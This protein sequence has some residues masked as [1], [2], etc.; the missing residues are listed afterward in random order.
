LSIAL[1]TPEITLIQLV[2]AFAIF[3][4]Q[5]QYQPVSII[6]KINQ[7]KGA[8]IE[9]TS[10]PPVEALTPSVTFLMNSLLEEVVKNGTAQGA[11]QL[12]RPVAGKT[13]TTN[14][15]RSAWFVGYTPD[16][17]TGVYV[18]MDDNTTLGK[19]EY[20]SK[21]ALPIW[22]SFMQAATQ[23][24]PRNAFQ[25]P[26][27]GVIKRIINTE[28]GLLADLSDQGQ[29][30]NGDWSSGDQKPASVLSGLL[31]QVFEQLKPESRPIQDA[32]IPLEPSAYDRDKAEEPY[33]T[34]H[35]ALPPNAYI[36]YFLEGT[37]PRK[38]HSELPPPPLEMLEGS[39][40][41]P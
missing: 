36:E 12:G 31:N 15:S 25:K 23:G 6:Q 4:A 2:N 1:G 17:V 29:Q 27:E 13:G 35:N 10:V 37:E 20:G 21:A 16:L 33:Y 22:R 40:F 9:F 7:P 8:P 19:H 39:G 11:K 41:A 28:S 18:G 30:A 3:P 24:T 38:R 14:E 26:E 32:G 34:G 5:G